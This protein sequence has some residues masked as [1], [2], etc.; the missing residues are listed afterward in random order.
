LDDAGVVWA[1]F[2]GAAAVYGANRPLTD[3]DILISLA[4][5][6]R[7][8]VLFPEAA[9]KRQEDGAVRSIRVPGVDL[10]AGLTMFE[11]DVA[12]TVDLDEQMAARRTRHEIAGVMVPV[13]PPEDNIL[14]KAMWRRGPEEGKHDWEDVRAM[15]SHLPSLDW[16]YMRWRAEMCGL[17]PGLQRALQSLEDLEQE[18]RSQSSQA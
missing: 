1:V 4:E 7:V 14:L 5:G 6:D 15:I 3:V 17:T 2:A 8:A 13:I 11:G 16:G 9:L 10:V 12:C 18:L